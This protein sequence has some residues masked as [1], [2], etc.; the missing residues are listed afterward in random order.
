MK[1]IDLIIP[2]YNAHN[3]LHRLFGSIMSQTCK[4]DI[5]II[6][7]DDCSDYGYEDFVKPFMGV[8]DI[9]IIK[10]EKNAGPGFARRVGIQ[11]GVSPYI[12]FADSDDTFYNSF[13]VEYLLRSI[14]Q[15]Q[16]DVVY[17]D[18][19]EEQDTGS[20]LVHKNDAIWVFGKIYRR[21]FLENWEIYFNDT[22]SNE[23]NGFNTLVR[24]FTN[25]VQVNEVTY[26]WHFNPQS[27]TRVND[28]L[29][30]FTSLEGQIYNKIWAFT[31]GYK[32]GWD[33]NLYL[34]NII[35]QFL[36]YYFHYFNIRTQTRK[37]VDV[38]LYMAWVKTYYFQFQKEIQEA[39]GNHMLDE[40]YA[41]VFMEY[42]NDHGKLYIHDVTIYDFIELLK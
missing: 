18:F 22:R 23:D 6:M 29:Y 25:P 15:S 40:E 35:G 39:I 28:C 41:T 38:K 2:C 1:K 3:T 10:L 5:H 12:I 4:D 34:R 7:V 36:Y 31:E 8:L 37:E 21:Q 24:C 26:I 14:E 32:K 20:F 30:T 33:R 13:S 17:S 9:E 42:Y 16:A 19:V 11:S 27:I